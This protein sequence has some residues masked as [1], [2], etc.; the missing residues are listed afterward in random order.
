MKAQQRSGIL[1]V[2]KRKVR[3]AD[4]QC[5]GSSVITSFV[6]QVPLGDMASTDEVAR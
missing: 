3:I 1:V 4:Q 6:K 5:G 2:L